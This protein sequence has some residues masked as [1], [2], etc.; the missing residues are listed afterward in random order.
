MSQILLEHN[1]ARRKAQQLQKVSSKAG[2]V[3]RV[4][5]TVLFRLKVCRGFLVEKC[6]NL[7]GIEIN[8]NLSRGLF[9]SM[10]SFR[11]RADENIGNFLVNNS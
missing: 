5:E 10:N 6:M 11:T 4:Q 8:T 1:K 7:T 3:Y 9:T 2:A